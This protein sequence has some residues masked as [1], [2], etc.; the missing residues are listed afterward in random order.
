M[1]E[2]KC[3]RC[4]SLDRILVAQVTHPQQWSTTVDQMRRM[5][6]SGISGDDGRVIAR[7]LVYRAFGRPGLVE[8]ERGQRP[9]AAGEP[10]SRV[11]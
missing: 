6:A 5:P 4:H 2:R 11:P 7:C 3:T 1:T 8:L 9:E 10:L